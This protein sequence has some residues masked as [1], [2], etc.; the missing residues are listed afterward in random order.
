MGDVGAHVHPAVVIVLLT[1]EIAG[2]DY[3]PLL[4]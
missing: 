4:P 2:V 3:V 1:W